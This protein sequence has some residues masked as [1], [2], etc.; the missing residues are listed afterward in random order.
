MPDGGKR[1]RRFYGPKRKLQWY[2]VYR[3]WR[4]NRR[5]GL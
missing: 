4:F 1:K 3:S 5:Y 2:A